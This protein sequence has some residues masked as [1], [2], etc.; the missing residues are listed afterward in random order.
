MQ[1]ILLKKREKRLEEVSFSSERM[2]MSVVHKFSD[3][4]LILT[5]GAPEVVIKKCNKIF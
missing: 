5:K 1:K 4:I 3:E 2:M